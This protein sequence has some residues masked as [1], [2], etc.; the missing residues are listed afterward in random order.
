M[1][2]K[3]I[4]ELVRKYE[5][6]LELGKSIY[7]DADDFDELADYFDTNAD[8]DAARDVIDAGL[9]IHPE[10]TSLLLKKAK[11]A[12]YDGEYTE[13]LR[14]L[15]S[16]TSYDFDSYL[17]KIECYLQLGLLAEAYAL[18]KE[19]LEE[20][21]TDL[22]NA[23]AEL[24]FLYV[25]ADYFDEA[26]LY[27]NKSLEYNSDNVDVLS[28]LAYAYEMLGDYDAAIVASNKILDIDSYSY[29]AWV[30]VGKL[31]S[32]KD[33]FEKAIDAFDFALAI[34]DSDENVLKL[35]AHCLSL[36]ERVSEAIEIFDGLLLSNPDDTS[37]YFLLAEC[38]QSLELYEE[39]LAYLD[40]YEELVGRSTEVVSKRVQ[41][42]LLQGELDAAFRLI[43][44]QMSNDKDS[45]D[46]SIIAGEIK[47]R[48]ELYD[49]AEAYLLKVYP[50]NQEDFHLLDMLAIVNVK[51]EDYLKAI[52]Y[53]EQLLDLDPLNLAV[54]QRLALLYF[55]INDNEQFNDLLEQFTDKELLSLFR[56]IYNPHSDEHFD[57]DQLIFYLN[58]ARE[59]RTLFKNLKY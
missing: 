26:I 39:A 43:D 54:K 18:T 38:Y 48:Q 24:G 5:E 9:A 21:D 14:L 12:A 8:T 55:E 40:Q 35:K 30:N 7:L 4:S 49:E 16:I 13:A 53:T 59:R 19:I 47:L 22:D 44:D 37:I 58:D 36:C 41:I 33:E 28:D 34:N 52:E 42:L 3:D 45:V 2:F 57:R 50:D 20:E 1:T 23:L 51:K 32:L 17:V 6:A 46:L 29:E 11:F 15:N 31:H 56:F 10:N 27:F 25:E